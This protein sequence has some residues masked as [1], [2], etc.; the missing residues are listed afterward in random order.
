M[1]EGLL[2]ESERRALS[3]PELLG[4]RLRVLS[5]NRRES[6]PIRHP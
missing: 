4:L 1:N 3:Q 2:A 5:T 6:S